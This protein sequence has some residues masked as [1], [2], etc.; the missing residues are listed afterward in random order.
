MLIQRTGKYGERILGHEVIR[1][2]LVAML[3]D[4]GERGYGYLAHFRYVSLAYLSLREGGK[5][6]K[7]KRGIN[8]EEDARGVV[9]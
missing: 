5:R 6:K 9:R 2:G 8:V 3:T 4:I 7:K 1:N